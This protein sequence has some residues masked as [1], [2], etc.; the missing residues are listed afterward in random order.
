M[1]PSAIRAVM[2]C[3]LVTSALGAGHVMAFE[4]DP[5]HDVGPSAATGKPIDVLAR[6]RLPSDAVSG[7][8][9]KTDDGYQT[10]GSELARFRLS[11]HPA[12]EYDFRITFTRTGGEG[13]VAQELRFNG[14]SFLWVMGAYN[15]RRSGFA[16][17]GE[18]GAGDNRTTVSKESVLT[19]GQRHMGEVRVRNDS[20]SAYLD[21]ELVRYMPTDYAD[22]S[23]PADWDVRGDRLGVVTESPLVLHA[24][25]VVPCVT[26]EGGMKKPLKNF[27]A[28]NERAADQARKNLLNA[29]D[30]KVTSIRK[31]GLHP[32]LKQIALQRVTSDREAFGQSEKLP[33]CDE[34]LGETITFLDEYQVKVLGNVESTR[35]TRVDQTVRAKEGPAQKPELAALERRFERIVGGREQF[36]EKSLWAGS[37]FFP[38]R[39]EEIFFFITD[40]IGN[41]FQGVV[42]QHGWDGGKMKVEGFLHGNA[43]VMQTTSMIE[44]KNRSLVFTGYLLSDR[45]IANVSG[46]NPDKQPAV[47]GV[48]WR[49]R[50]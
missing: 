41:G 5:A 30:K 37:R 6:V 50:K 38:D 48:S 49:K 27:V 11:Y 25:V 16:L 20:V 4:P 15:N 19:N 36:T 34:L 13:R 44:G 23:C 17:V 3:G 18:K 26:S 32:D 40:K 12:G 43:F 9:K 28:K 22:L 14:K 2:I 8:W 29:M 24:A 1:I 42:D 33:S 7:A 31:S 46:I 35:L 10:E 47:G 45:M 39:S 21:G